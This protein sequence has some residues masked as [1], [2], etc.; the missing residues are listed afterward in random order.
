[1]T[2]HD[3]TRHNAHVYVHAC[4][5]LKQILADRQLQYEE[6][7]AEGMAELKEFYEEK[8]NRLVHVLCVHAGIMASTRRAH[9]L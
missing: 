9:E 5:Q 1:M 2:R 3:I 8:V 4:V 6:E 7:K